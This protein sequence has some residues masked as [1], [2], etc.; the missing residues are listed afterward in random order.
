MTHSRP[1]PMQTDEDRQRFQEES[2]HMISEK[3]H[4]YCEDILNRIKFIVDNIIKYTEN[5]SKREYFTRKQE[6]DIEAIRIKLFW[7]DRIMNPQKKATESDLDSAIPIISVYNRD[8]EP[9]FVNVPYLRSIGLHSYQELMTLYKKWRLYDEI[10][11][12]SSLA[13]ISEKTTKIE[14]TW[15]YVDE[16]FE[17]RITKKRLKFNTIYNNILRWSVRIAEDITD[18]W[19]FADYMPK[20]DFSSPPEWLKFSWLEDWQLYKKFIRDIMAECPKYKM[21]VDHFMWWENNFNK[22]IGYIDHMLCIWDYIVDRW[23]YAVYSYNWEKHFYNKRYVQVTNYDVESFKEL[24]DK[25]NVVDALY[26]YWNELN[27][28]LSKVASLSPWWFY[29][30]VFTIRRMDNTYVDVAWS[31]YWYRKEKTSFRI[32]KVVSPVHL[33]DFLLSVRDLKAV[34]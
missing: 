24:F 11:T 8:Q 29:N 18:L 34:F 13:K 33:L 16:I 9:I 21:I 10:Y 4:S 20:N 23:P 22:L 31:T 27:N 6:M 17:T 32:W 12:D 5:W 3:T 28:V 15:W 30:A 14:E 26:W 25:W 1:N 19:I 7:I 2:F